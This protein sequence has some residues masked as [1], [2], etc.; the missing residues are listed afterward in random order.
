MFDPK[1][2][3]LKHRATK[4]NRYQ[5]AADAKLHYIGHNGLAK[6]L[7]RPDNFSIVK[8]CVVFGVCNMKK[9]HANHLLK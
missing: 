4:V 7:L 6:H 1:S 9:N 5:K 2:S 8:L 3:H